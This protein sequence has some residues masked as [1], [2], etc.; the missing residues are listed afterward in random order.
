[1]STNLD[2][3]KSGQISAVSYYDEYKLKA[4]DSDLFT[5]QLETTEPALR[6]RFSI[7]PGL[8]CP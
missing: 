5:I 1:M 6:F 8:V 7:S 2:P 3:S 4:T